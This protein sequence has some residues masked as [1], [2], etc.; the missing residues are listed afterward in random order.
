MLKTSVHWGVNGTGLT[1][2]LLA[3]VTSVKYCGTFPKDEP[4]GDALVVGRTFREDGFTKF[5]GD[6]GLAALNYVR[7]SLDPVIKANPH[8]QYWESPN[9]PVWSWDDADAGQNM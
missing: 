5:V 8:V 3:G 1:P 4:V 7:A 2:C 6:P 9:E